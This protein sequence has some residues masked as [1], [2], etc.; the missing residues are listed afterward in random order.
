MKR[1]A[2]FTGPLARI[3]CVAWTPDSRH[4]ASGGLDTNL[5]IFNLENP[6]NKIAI[7]GKPD[8]C[9]I[10]ALFNNMRTLKFKAKLTITF[11]AAVN[12]Y[13]NGHPKAETSKMDR[14]LPI[15]NQDRDL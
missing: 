13:R 4:L 2:E 8:L 10:I 6:N 5:F 11:Y 9:G 3:T 7:R 12:R 15:T 1:F 14:N